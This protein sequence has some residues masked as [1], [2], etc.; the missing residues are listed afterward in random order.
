MKIKKLVPFF[1][2]G[3]FIT[4]LV[5]AQSNENQL[6][7]VSKSTVKP[8]KLEQYLE[9]SE[10]WASACK[11]HNYP[12]TFH[13]WRSNIY[14]FYWF[15]PVDDYNQVTETTSEA[16][17]IVPKLEEGFPAKYFE[18]IEYSE[19]FFIRWID[20]LAYNPQTSVE[21]LVY[22]EWWIHYMKP[23]TGLNFRKAF[24]NA[25]DIRK[26]ANFEYPM[27]TLQSDIG[28]NGGSSYISVFWGKDVIDLNS[29]QNKAW[30]LLD[31]EA[32]QMIRDLNPL[33]RKFEIIGF[34]YQEELSYSSD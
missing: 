32:Q 33:R 10:K 15:Y 5:L 17:N 28:M 19:S 12:Y 3:F 13:V 20:S 7:F 1:V 24:K 27:A 18:N 8:E 34:W 31:E 26:K 22:V 30:D 29:K 2:I 14:D 23:W 11:E 21:G 4:T 6:Y 25:A 9:L 16:W